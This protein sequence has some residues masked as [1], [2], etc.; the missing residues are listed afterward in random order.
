MLAIWI[1]IG[2][3][4]ACVFTMPLLR[5][6]AHERM[7]QGLQLEGASRVPRLLGLSGLRVERRDWKGDLVFE[8]ARLGGGHP[9]HLRVLALFAKPLQPI[10]E[11]APIQTGDAEFD[12]KIAV[13][14]DAAFAKKFLGPE[15]RER[16]MDLDRLGGRVLAIREES[17]EIDGPLP[18]DAASLRRFLELCDVIISGA[19]AAAGA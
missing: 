16:L 2:F 19:G 8:A 4:A 12:R 7:L 11:G 10:R 9:G 5:K 18:A 3:L 15:M 14:G 6:L 17:I 1:G 13:E